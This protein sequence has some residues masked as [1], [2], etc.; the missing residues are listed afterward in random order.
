MVFWSIVIY[1]SLLLEEI[2]EKIVFGISLGDVLSVYVWI[3]F[4]DYYNLWGYLVNGFF[5][6][7]VYVI[8]L[9]E[10]IKR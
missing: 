5:F 7:R 1:W 9:L 3:V 10:S 4:F 2:D 6:Y 8:K